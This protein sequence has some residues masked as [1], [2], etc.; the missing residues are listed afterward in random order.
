VEQELRHL[1]ARANAWL[2][3]SA[4]P[5]SARRRTR[6]EQEAAAEE[7]ELRRSELE[8]A[9][10][11]AEI[12]SERAAQASENLPEATPPGARRRP[13]SPKCSG[14]CPVRAGGAAGT[15]Q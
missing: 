8:Q 1:H 2:R 14:K 7:M 6:A 13:P 5:A 12:L 10:E 15:G 4:L 11:Q 9:E 3:R